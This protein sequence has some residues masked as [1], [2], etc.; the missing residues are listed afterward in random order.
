[1]AAWEW[2]R[3]GETA[4]A[5]SRLRDLGD[6]WRSSR[7]E[8]RRLRRHGEVEKC[9]GVEQMNSSVVRTVACGAARRE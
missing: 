7:R 1:M 9:D 5:Q 3:A 2:L 8:C 6:E 4:E